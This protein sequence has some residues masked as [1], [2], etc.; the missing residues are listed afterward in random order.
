VVEETTLRIEHS[1][2]VDE[3]RRFDPG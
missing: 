2:D 3:V 1:P